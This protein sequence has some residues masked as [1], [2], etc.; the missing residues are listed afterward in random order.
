MRGQF[1]F[2]SIIGFCIIGFHAIFILVA[3]WRKW[4]DGVIPD[5]YKFPH[6]EIKLFIA[7]SMGMMDVAFGILAEP[8]TAPGWKV[9]YLLDVSL[10]LCFDDII[11]IFID[12]CR[13]VC[14]I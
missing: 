13:C 6:I 3:K 14:V 5:M 11:Y 10:K 2:M 12:D 1:F 4:F 7:L 8:K 9:K